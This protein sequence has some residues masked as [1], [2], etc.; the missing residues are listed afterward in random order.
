MLKPM[1]PLP[2]IPW[3]GKSMHKLSICPVRMRCT[4]MVQTKYRILQSNV[5][6]LRKIYMYVDINASRGASPVLYIVLF[7]EHN[8]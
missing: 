7:F 1:I 8:F 6:H 3:M 5:T 4:S 2:F